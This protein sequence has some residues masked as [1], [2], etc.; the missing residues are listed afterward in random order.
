MAI[1]G[2]LKEAS[3][4]DVCQL[5]ALG[6]KTGSLSVTDRSNFGQIYFDEGRVTFARII[7]RRDRLGDLMVRDGLLTHDQIDHA[8]ALQ[9]E[10]PDRRLGELLV[11][12]G[13]ITPAQLELYVRV[14]IEEAIYYLFTWDRGNFYFEADEKPDAAEILVSINPESLLMEGARRVD[15][16][17]QI[18]KKIPSLD[19]IFELDRE[20][21][22]EIHVQ[23]TEQ[24]QRILPHIDGSTSLQ[25]IVD[26]T[27]VVE[28]D[29]GKA[30]YGLLQAG[31]ARRVGRRDS[32]QPGRAREADVQEHRNLAI[33]FYETGMMEEATREYRKV[34]E[35]R[36]NDL[37]AKHRLALVALTEG[38]DREAVR[39]LKTVLEEGGPRYSAFL[40]MGHALMRLGRAADAL[41]VLQ[42]AEALRQ[43]TPAAALARAEAHL[44]L[45][46]ARDALEALAHFRER[47]GDAARRP[48]RYHH[49]VA[50]AHAMTGDLHEAQRLIETGLEQH[51]TSAPLHVLAGAVAERRGH[52]ER[53]A[54]HYR[55]AIEEDPQL[56]QGHKNLGDVAY[57]QGLHEDAVG[58]FE[59]AI[60]LAPDLGGDVY[61]KMGNIRYKQ[62][63]REDAVAL[64]RRALELNPQ[65]QVVRN[66]LEVVVDALGSTGAA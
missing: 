37:D 63:R 55:Q 24:Q 19:L 52:L 45:A 54:E 1:K 56:P 30:M 39:R 65:N 57:R 59:R 47:D 28:F 3:L 64:W 20:R 22:D 2:S 46:N 62:H 33:A 7:N 32:I 61:T 51:P 27:G 40:N 26:R 41:L 14:Q 8:V 25:E 44:H 49:A 48:A 66:N 17:S 21:L 4:A 60:E 6:L 11:E 18:E 15:E 38:Q 36:P 34:L 53:A 50:L 43:G 31:F 29:V 5:L 12:C 42:E 23:L 16:W 35:L 9:R 10:R 13:Y 58:H